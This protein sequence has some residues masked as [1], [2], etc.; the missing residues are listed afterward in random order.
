MSIEDPTH[1][2]AD[3]NF[4]GRDSM[5]ASTDTEAAQMAAAFA[6]AA[7]MGSLEYR[8]RALGDAA[9]LTRLLSAH[10]ALTSSFNLNPETGM[11]R[12]G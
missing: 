5:G 9:A 6:L 3:G 7:L 4:P 12:H 1:D 2:Q 10:S 11:D 8:L